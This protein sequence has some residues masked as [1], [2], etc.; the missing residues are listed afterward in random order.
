MGYR[1]TD[2]DKWKDGWFRKLKANEK[3]LFLY[4]IDNCNLAGFLEIDYEMISFV[5]GMSEDEILG[6][7][8]GLNRGCF[9]V[10]GW[11]WI[12]NFLKHQKNLPLNPENNAHKH[13]INLVQEQSERFKDVPEFNEF[14]GANKGLLSPPGKGKGN[15][16]GKGNVNAEYFE[17][18]WEKYPRKENRKKSLESFAKIAPDELLLGKMLAAIDTQ[19]E[20]RQWKQG[21]IP[22]ASTWLNQKRFED[23]L[24]KPPDK[25][26]EPTSKFMKGLL[27]GKN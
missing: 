18:F 26:F 2:A 14:L 12:K 4:F 16:K 21:Y 20:T 7:V 5:T 9:V 3:L 11:L 22:H 27:N 25:T 10:D 17:I 19:K 8:Q 6:A 24:D 1:L 13:I 15:S 23:E